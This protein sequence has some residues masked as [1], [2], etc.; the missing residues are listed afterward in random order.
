MGS[1]QPWVHSSLE[2]SNALDV[3]LLRGLDRRREL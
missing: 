1:F 3:V 2:K